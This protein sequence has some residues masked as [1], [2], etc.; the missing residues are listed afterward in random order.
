M[1]Y[2]ELCQALC[3]EAD[4]PGGGTVPTAVTGQAGELQR[5]VT[6]I[7]NAYVEIQNRHGYAWRWLRNE[8][9]IATVAST[10]RYAWDDAAVT[11]ITGG[12]EGAGSALT[13]FNSWDV[14]DRIDP[15][16]IYLTSGGVG[17]ENWMIYVPWEWFRNIYEIG[18]QSDGY[19]SHVSV[20]PQNNLVIGPAPDAVYTITGLFQGGAQ[21]LAANGDTPVLPVQYHQLIVCKAL[22]KY[23]YFESDQATLNRAR[24]EG[25]RLMRQLEG[26][27]LQPMRVRGPMA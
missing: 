10:Y 6:W 11:D 16:K 27:Q 4:L 17:T 12:N 21:V 23:A 9:E 5:M 25:S 26:D 15:P 18:T 2:L 24:V 19:P 7:T 20:D 8:F 22:E 14:N 3:L 13:T 1:T